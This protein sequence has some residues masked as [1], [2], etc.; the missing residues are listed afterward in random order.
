MTDSG[1]DVGKF[2]DLATRAHGVP[3]S[4]IRCQLDDVFSYA[5]HKKTRVKATVTFPDGTKGI[6]NTMTWFP[7][8]DATFPGHPAISGLLTTDG[9]V[10]PSSQVL[11]QV[12]VHRDVLIWLVWGGRGSPLLQATI[13]WTD[14]FCSGTS[15][16]GD[17]DQGR[18][19][20][21]D[22]DL[23]YA[24]FPPPWPPWLLD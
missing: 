7:P 4:V 22:F 17:D 14:V 9:D 16:S 6:C 24:G 2:A 8:D 21:I 23:W 5:S 12:Q 11:G 18:H 3:I 15:L 13:Q 10:N 1:F 20:N 19:W